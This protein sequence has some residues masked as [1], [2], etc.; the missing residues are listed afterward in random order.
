MIGVEDSLVVVDDRNSSGSLSGIARL[1]AHRLLT[2]RAH[3]VGPLYCWL[4]AFSK[5]NE[6]DNRLDAVVDGRFRQHAL[7]YR[8]PFKSPPR[9]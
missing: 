4:R 8:R 6:Q 2:T 9:F 3:R 1:C 5:E 7:L